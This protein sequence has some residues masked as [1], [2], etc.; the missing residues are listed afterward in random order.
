MSHA[1]RLSLG[2][3]GGLALFFALGALARTVAER[4][5]GGELASHAALKV[6]ACVAALAVGALLGL[7][8]AALGFVRGRPLG[9]RGA[10]RWYLLAAAG[11]GAATL[12]MIFSGARHPMTAGLSFPQ[13]VLSVWLLSSFA[14]EFFVRG[15]VQ[16]FMGGRDGADLGARPVVA[17]SAALFAAL[18]VPLLWSGAGAVG[19]GAIVVATFTVGWAAAELRARSGSLF[20]PVLVHVFGNVASLPFGVV[21]VLVYRAIYGVLPAVAGG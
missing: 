9:R 3:V 14:E 13:L 2:F 19:G 21:G 17:T 6:A 11:M 18:H 12:V 10:L 1:L 7:R 15:L 5:G 4:V 16:T 8:P 20:H